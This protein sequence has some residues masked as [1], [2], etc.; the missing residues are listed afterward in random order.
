[1]LEE[2]LE[3]EDL[4]LHPAI[5]LLELGAV[6]KQR[7][8]PVILIG[9]AIRAEAELEKA[10]LTQRFHEKCGG[11]PPHLTRRLRAPC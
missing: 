8:H 6:A 1:M 3:A 4:I 10:E 5:G 7:Q 11:R 2:V 9:F